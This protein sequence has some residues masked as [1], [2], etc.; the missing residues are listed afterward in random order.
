MRFSLEKVVL[1]SNR[2]VGPVRGKLFEAGRVFKV[3]DYP[4]LGDGVDRSIWNSNVERE[5]RAANP[6]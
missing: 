6:E 2:N 5:T 3:S 1:R 4:E